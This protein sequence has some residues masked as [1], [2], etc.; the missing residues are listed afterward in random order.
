MNIRD[1]N[2]KTVC[3]LGYGREGRATVEALEKYAP[4][5]DITIADANPKIE[6]Q[7]PKHWKQLGE[8]WLENLDKFDVLIKSPGIPPYAQRPTYKF[9]SNFS[10]LN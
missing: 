8:G 3:M 4:E 9:Y 1:L 5:S 2:G 10:R 6:I 7:N